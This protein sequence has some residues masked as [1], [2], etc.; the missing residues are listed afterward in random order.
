MI[1]SSLSASPI[2]LGFI[3]FHSVHLFFSKFYRRSYNKCRCIGLSTGN[4][5]H[6][7]ERAVVSYLLFSG[8]SFS[9]M[10]QLKIAI[11]FYSAR[12]G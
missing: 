3:T 2:P 6:K 8:I 1:Y 10:S 4:R 12:V 5:Y 7:G 9:R 11:P